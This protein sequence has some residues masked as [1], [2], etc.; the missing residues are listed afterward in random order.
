MFTDDIGY[1]SLL[2]TGDKFCPIEVVLKNQ[3]SNHLK[4]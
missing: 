1:N 3:R 4:A 2:S